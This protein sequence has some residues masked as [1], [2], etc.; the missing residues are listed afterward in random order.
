MGRA[1]RG[2]RDD[3]AP[4]AGA[5]RRAPGGAGPAG[6]WRRERAH[7]MGALRDAGAVAAVSRPLILL[8]AL[9]AGEDMAAKQAIAALDEPFAHIDG[10]HLARVQVLR[11]PAR[12]WRGRPR[13]Y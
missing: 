6:P 3:E 8:A 9:R 11:P 12:R 7:G 2:D 13:P 1:S 5:E 4:G 10:T